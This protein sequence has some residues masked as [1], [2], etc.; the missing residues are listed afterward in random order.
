MS[1]TDHFWNASFDEL[2]QGYAERE[3][4]FVCLLC[5]ETVEKGIIYPV[6]GLLFEAAKF[7]ARHIDTEHGSVFQ[8]LSQLDKRITGLSD[9]QNSLMRL[10]YQGLSDQEVQ[11][12][13][14]IGSASTIRNHRFALKEKER[15]AKVF[16]VMMEL[17]KGTGKKSS[18]LAPAQAV[19]NKKR[20]SE[21]EV[22][23]M[24]YAQITQKYFPEGTL[25]ALHLFPRKQK[26][27]LVVLEEISKRFDPKKIYTEKEVNAILE[28]VYEADYVTI[29]RYLIDYAFLERNPDGSGYWVKN[30]GEEQEKNMDRKQELKQLYKEVKTEA[31][32][33]Q[34][35]NTRNGK[36][37]IDGT[38]NLKTMNG[39]QFMLKHGSHTVKDLQK[40]WEQ[41]GE[42]AFV[43]EVLEVLEKKDEPYF[44]AADALEKLE[45]K[46]LDKLQ[47]YGDKGYNERKKQ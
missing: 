19:S 45:D 38:M 12:E 31:G 40:D 28:A 16:L 4:D 2:K 1:L 33:Y 41:Y 18:H 29:R 35:R 42:E 8:H 17:M 36:V 11:K 7:M 23:P 15:Q 13:L 43:F 6:D 3:H 10:F 30:T 32:V 39:K 25:G 22:S 37:W 44:D 9:H 20:G 47:P 27:R 34:I 21:Q 5:G 24:E 26:H 46:W 14:G